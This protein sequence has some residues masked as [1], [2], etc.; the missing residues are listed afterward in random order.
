MSKTLK[1]QWQFGE[2]FPS[3]QMRR[4]CTVSEITSTVRRLIE[5][6][7][8]SVWVTGEIT[9]F[10]RQGSGHSYFAIKD[11][12]AQLSCVL[13]RDEA[14]TFSREALRDGLQVVLQGTMTVYEV[15]GQYQLRVTSVELQGV[16]V[17]QAAFEK[18]KQKLAAEGLFA[19]ERK[20]TLPRF[21]RRIGIVTSPTAAALQDVAHVIARRHPQLEI[22]LA[23]CRVQGQGAAMEIAAAIRQLNEFHASS[24]EMEPR[25]LDLILVTRGGGS[26]EDL[27]A[28]NEEIVARAIFESG[29]PVVSAVGHEI[30]FSISDFVADVRAA[31]PSA[32][33]EV[34]TE[35]IVAS[36]AFVAE[37]GSRLTFL[38]HRRIVETQDELSRTC[39]R[40]LRVHPRRRL[41]EAGQ[42]IDDLAAGLSRVVRLSVRTKRIEGMQVV[43]RFQRIRPAALLTRAETETD[44]LRKRLTGQAKLSLGR[45]QA[46]LE[47]AI[48]QLRVLSP[49]SVLERGFSITTLL[50]TGEVVR[51]AESLQ[52]GT[53]LRT[54]LRNGRV[55]SV[56]EQSGR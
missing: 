36:R 6:Q 37:A 5:G 19:T 44:R 4:I 29:V 17:L 27:W 30:D 40:L 48:A 43:E 49:A 28:F 13:F 50:E 11:A 41:Q 24:D 10:R 12:S 32:A 21:P 33:A 42:R 2:L 3:E 31:T 15:R 51:D 53:R 26:L 45:H 39:D 16:G 18:L 25:E 46:R 9:N 1:S 23:P 14:R 47:K 55:V 22:V 7:V 56:V 35:Q 8:G 52:S 38:A 34:I 54:T 20:R